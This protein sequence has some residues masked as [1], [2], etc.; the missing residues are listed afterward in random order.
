LASVLP[1]RFPHPDFP[2]TAQTKA[3]WTLTDAFARKPPPVPGG[4]NP[5]D[6]IYFDAKLPRFGLRRRNG[7]LTWIV[8][9]RVRG[10]TKRRTL[11]PADGPLALGA[12]AARSA[13][14]TRLA[15]ISLGAD[16]ASS[17]GGL[18]LGLAVDRYLAGLRSGTV[19]IG[20]SRNRKI[21][22]ASLA[23]IATH[24]SAHWQGLRNWPIHTIDRRARCRRTSCHCGGAWPGGSQPRA[25]QPVRVFPLGHGRGHRRSKPGHWHQHR[26]GKR[27]APAR[28]R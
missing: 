21:R 28:A 8:Q 4:N 26:A 23:A 12:K 17:R 7:S 24:L 6:Y 10:A 22:A 25:R 19:G 11:G 9:Y 18:R 3:T 5:N 20:R 1:Q 15:E 13:A 2:M 14:A 16:P 27:S